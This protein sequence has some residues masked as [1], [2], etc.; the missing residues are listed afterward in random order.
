MTCTSRPTRAGLRS[1]EIPKNHADN[2]END[3]YTRECKPTPWVGF[4][5]KK[6]RCQARYQIFLD[7]CFLNLKCRT[8]K[9]NLFTCVL[10]AKCLPKISFLLFIGIWVAF[11]TSASCNYLITYVILSNLGPNLTHIHSSLSIN[12]IKKLSYNLFAELFNLQ[13]L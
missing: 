9:I 11:V 3:R 6:I 1:T 13:T 8:H 12:I 4:G 7:V 2:F 10:R 5:L